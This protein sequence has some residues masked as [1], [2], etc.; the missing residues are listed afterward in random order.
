MDEAVQ[1]SLKKSKPNRKIYVCV[2]VCVSVCV[3]IH[4]CINTYIHACINTYIH[5]YVLHYIVKQSGMP[6]LTSLI[7]ANALF[8]VSPIE[9][10][11]LA[12]HLQTPVLSFS[13]GL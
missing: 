10:F 1:V 4:V 2:G 13:T 5:I 6:W 9:V 11:R 7:K 3:Y 12:H 8:P